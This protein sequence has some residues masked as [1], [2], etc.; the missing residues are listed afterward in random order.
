MAISATAFRRAVTV[1][2][3][4]AAIAFG[5]LF[6]A[7]AQ[8]VSLTGAGATFPALLY[9]RYIAEFQ[10][11]NPGIKVNYQAIGSGAG[12]R[13]TIAGVVDFGGS[14][15][16]MSDA[17]IAKVPGNKGGV[18]LVPTAGGSV[19]PVFNLPGVS[20][21]RLSRQV[22]PDI[23]SG[24]ITR[25]ND[26]RI[27][28]D[29]PGVSLPN[30]EIKTVVRADGSGT[31]FIFVNHLSAVSPYFRGRVGVGTAPNWTT[32]PIKGR[33]NAGVSAQVSRTPNSLGYVEYS[34]AVENKIPV[35]EVQSKQGEWFGP[36]LEA[37]N[38]AIASLKMPDNFRIFNGDPDQ[39]YP[40]SG[41]TWMM[42]YKN[43]GNADKAK[44]VRTWL[45]WVLTDGQELNDDL[46]F[47]RISPEDTQRVLQVV[48][49]EIKP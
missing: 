24:R 31:T 45:E 5:P 16:A 18:I 46:N 39:G 11:K 2:A 37:T 41:L 32:N 33:G 36:S 23:F 28:K 4:S 10:K 15:A 25:W 38:R 21:L 26:S 27:A 20:K 48:R 1:S 8:A 7:I 12:I 44:A 3:V 43:Y 47:A 30:A 29:N 6:T 34:Y 19:V 49:N 22:L 17:D 9:E 42:V 40:I 14:D 13:Q 35:A